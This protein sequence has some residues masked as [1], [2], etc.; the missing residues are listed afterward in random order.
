MKKAVVAICALS[1]AAGA[2]AQTLHVY[3]PGGPLAPMQ[4]CA[5]QYTAQT[6]H[7]VIVTGG[8]EK[9]WFAA[10][11]MDGDVI[12][13]GAEYMLTQFDMEHPGFLLAGSRTDLYKRTAGILV[14]PG[15][16]KH[17]QTLADLAKP[18][19]HLLDV[20]G[21]GQLGLWEDIAGRSGLIDGLQRNIAMTVATSAEG[22]HAWATRP[23]LDAW[24]T[25]ESWQQRM[26]QEA[27]L[28]RLPPE[29]RI[30][31]GTPIAFTQRSTLKAEAKAFLAQLRTPACHSVFIHAGWQ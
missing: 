18:G 4:A 25:Y 13:G 29:M 21:A 10:A 30:Y 7:P 16:P 20:S 26:P 17:I 27:A 23:Q 24:I 14:R 28:V 22:M 19:I 31:R 1:Y 8:P 2:F 11:Q 6:H 12:Y 15:N 5:A 9:Q 3:G